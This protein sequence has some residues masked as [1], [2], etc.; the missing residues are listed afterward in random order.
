MRVTI[1]SKIQL[2]YSTFGLTKLSILEAIKSV[3]NA[4]YHGIEL[5]FHKSNFNPFDLTDARLQKIKQ[6]LKVN[7]L[8][9]ACISAPTYFF[10]DERPHEPSLICTDLAGR[11]QRIDLIKRAIKVAR[12]LESPLVC[13]G[14]GF[15]REEHVNNPNINPRKL[16]I[17]SIHDCLKEVGDVTLV[18]EPEPG[19]YIE[20]INDGIELVKEI[21]NQQFRLHLDLNH[22][23]C[24]DHDY[25]FEIATA[26]SLTRYLHISDTV[27][28]YNVKMVSSSDDAHFDLSKTNYLIYYPKRADYLLLDKQHSLYFHDAPLSIQEQQEIMHFAYSINQCNN[29]EYVDYNTLTKSTSIYDP[30]IAVYGF[31]IQNMSFYVVDRAKPILRYIRE[32]GIATKMIANTI[33]GRVHFHEIPGKGDINIKGCFDA[34]INNG[35]SGY[36]S[37]ELYHHAERWQEALSDSFN[38]L[39][40]LLSK[41]K[42][43]EEME[44][45]EN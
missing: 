15:L 30:E 31:S 3:A 10:M 21:N 16:L 29:I 38:Y 35:F 7:A 23:S 28:G 24:G 44:K 34:L 33:T 26:A 41:E 13:F 9:P 5:A 36:G 32:R 6:A 12:Y 45:M 8:F 19:M 4:G 27:D 20:T 37:V 11:K 2:A 14:S 22:V 39:T 18:I 43:T 40:Q 42:S 25:L 1:I 17:D